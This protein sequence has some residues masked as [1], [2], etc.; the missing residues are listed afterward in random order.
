[1][2]SR[3]TVLFAVQVGVGLTLLI[4]AGEARLALLVALAAGSLC[5]T[6]VGHIAA[7]VVTLVCLVAGVAVINFSPA[8]RARPD[9]EPCAP[10][11][12][13]VV[14]EA[15]SDTKPSL[16]PIHPGRSSTPALRAC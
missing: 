11:V 16:R 9:D 7:A 1:M 3:R 10:P 14:S 2:T 15:R 13:A 6:R 8:G 12:G 5:A 4:A